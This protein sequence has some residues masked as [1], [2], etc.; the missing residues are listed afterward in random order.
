[1]SRCGTTLTKSAFLRVKF[2]LNQAPMADGD[3][4][5][6]MLATH[7]G[8]AAFL[9]KKLIRRLLVDDPD[10]AMIDRIAAVFMAASDAPDQIAQV[11]R[12]IVAEPAFLD[13]PP[14]KLRRRFE[15]LAGLYRATGAAVKSPE[16]PWDWQLQPAGWH[17][18]TYGPPSGHR[19][20]TRTGHPDRASRWSSTSTLNR[21]V[22][23]AFFAH[24][25]WLGTTDMKLGEATPKDAQSFAEVVGF[26]VTKLRG[27]SS[28]DVLAELANGYGI[29][30][31]TAPL[32]LSAD[33]LP[34]G[35]DRGHAQPFPGRGASNGRQRPGMPGAG[36]GGG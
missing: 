13:N 7:P 8:T 24:D 2:E 3:R 18:H 36:W 4:V 14:S 12:A 20:A 27:E 16:M 11:I 30:D 19:L 25:E 5:L 35:A 9:C 26:W 32:D 23:L 34:G 1:M 29:T 6:D 21:Y 15:F 33:D 17:Q 28:H 22:D 31:L 10:P